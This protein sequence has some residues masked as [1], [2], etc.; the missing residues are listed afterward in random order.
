MPEDVMLKE[1]IEAIRQ[2]QQS[3]ARDLLTR[4]LRAD[5]NNAGYW[6]W[7]SAVVESEREQIF[8]LKKA[9]RF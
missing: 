5:S 6:I 3:R 2:G 7:M 4:L 1:A 9:A 8:C